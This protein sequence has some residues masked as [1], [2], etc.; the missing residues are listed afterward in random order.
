MD[1]TAHMY[2]LTGW[3]VKQC[4]YHKASH[5]TGFLH[6]FCQVRFCCYSRVCFPQTMVVE[7]AP[8]LS[9]RRP[10]ALLLR[11]QHS[12]ELVYLAF[13][14]REE[15]QQWM[16][17]IHQAILDLRVWGASAC[18]YIIPVPSSKFYVESPSKEP[19]PSVTTPHKAPPTS[20]VRNYECP[21]S[22]SPSHK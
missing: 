15:K 14:S 17:T 16:G 20:T 9:M 12:M 8:R 11:D 5:L 19:L 21:G 2:Y 6:F 10:N 4:R 18:D 1:T 13:E 7:T 3:P 22:R